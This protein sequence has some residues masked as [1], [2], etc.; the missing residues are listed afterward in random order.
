MS[1]T[2]D[3]FKRYH[4]P[5]I[6]AGSAHASVAVTGTASTLPTLG[7]A[8]VT[9]AGG[10]RVQAQTAA[11]RYTLGGTNPTTSTGFSLDV[12]Q[13]ADLTPADLATAKWIAEAGSP[14]LEIQALR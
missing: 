5:S 8:A 11:V 9:G 2:D 3:L 13:Y 4:A 10:Y 6:V 12:R 1:L 7:Y 14:K